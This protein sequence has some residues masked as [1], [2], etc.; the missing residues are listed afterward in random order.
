M[1]LFLLVISN[2]LILFVNAQIGAYYV[3]PEL[4]HELARNRKAR[5][6]SIHSAVLPLHPNDSRIIT[7]SSEEAFDSKL[8]WNNDKW[9]AIPLSDIQTGYENGT[10]L[11]I[12]SNIGAGLSFN[13]DK[14]RVNANY[15]FGYWQTNAHINS[16]ADSMEIIPGIGYAIPTSGNYTSHTAFGSASF[17]PNKFFSFELGRDKHFI[18]HGYRSLILSDNANVYPY[19]KIDTKVW[20][21]RYTNIY[22]WMQDI[23][24]ANGDPSKYRNK[25][26]TTHFLDWNITKSWSIGVFETIIWQAKDTLL[27]RGYD[28][29]YLNPVIF[30]RPV[31]FAQGSADNAIMALNTQIKVTSNHHIYSQFVIDEFLLE[32]L[33][34]DL[35]H[36]L[37]PNDTTVEYGWWANKYAFQLG[38]KYFNVA[39]IESLDFQSEFNAIRPYTFTHGS[40]QQNYAH[41]NQAM[42]HPRGANFYEWVNIIRYQKERLKVRNQF[43]WSNYGL[44]KDSTNFGGNLFQEYGSRSGT[45]YQTIAQGDRNVLL[46]N[47]LRFSYIIDS[48]SRLEADFG[49]MWRNNRGESYSTNAHFIYLGLRTKLWSRY[50]DY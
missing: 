42:A 21:I 3:S 49:W 35:Y 50:Y 18:G 15:L 17:T 22:S 27:N 6:D 41:F 23:Q 14:W 25:F 9:S 37:Q 29:N 7:Y 26:T 13:T 11:V 5:K 30:Y 44:D 38:Y 16:I 24:I 28:I 31:E 10:G 20:K 46:F 43:V 40:T 47:D 8:S 19:F 1:R 2:I 4:N 34:A 33:R 45:F 12:N 39:G 48:K 32:N 36:F